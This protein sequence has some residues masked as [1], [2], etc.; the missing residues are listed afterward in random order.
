MRYF[1]PKLELI[2]SSVV[3]LLIVIAL[4]G[5]AI[6][7]FS[8]ILVYLLI[9]L[10]LATL[11][12][13]L[14]TSISRAQVWGFHIP[15]GLAIF[16][17][18][19]LVLL[20][21]TL[22]VGQ[23]VPLVSNQIEVLSDMDF[24]KLYTQATEPLLRFEEF[25]RRNELTQREPGF[26]VN[27]MRVYINKFFTQ[28]DFQE[29]LNNVIGFTG[30]LLIGVMAV[31]F[32]TYFLLQEKGILRRNLISLIPN[33]FFEVSIAAVYKIEKLLSNYLLALFFQMFAV[34]SIA[35]L[36]LS[37]FGIRYALTIGVFAAVANLIPY[38]G[39]ILGAM[40]GIV[41]AISTTQILPGINEYVFLVAKILAVFGTVQ[42]I[43]NV[44]IQ[45]LIF[46]KSVKAH[47]LE[48]FLVIFAGASVGN[49]VG[50][51]II[52]MIL[53]VP[54]YTIIRVSFLEFYMGYSQYQ[55]FRKPHEQKEVLR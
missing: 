19:L 12:R 14:V 9:S 54:V 55:V 21:L 15:R 35:S 38:A 37:L 49:Q 24:D 28:V 41:V 11:L 8:N 45:P 47:P 36:G 32:I 46:S 52:G 43:D 31:L 42:L 13:P 51:S 22:F 50:S 6:W 33:Q 27:S 48:I 40:F 20:V 25:L 44:I 3:V 17:S 10:I 2:K 29:I 18:Y 16:I 5:L 4:L 34:F 26:M 39:P 7:L 23:F 53:A 30:S 1:N